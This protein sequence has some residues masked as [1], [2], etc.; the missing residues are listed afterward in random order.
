[1]PLSSAWKP[2]ALKYR[3]RYTDEIL[4]IYYLHDDVSTSQQLTKKRTKLRYLAALHG[5]IF[6]LSYELR[7]FV[8]A[9]LEFFKTAAV[10]A[11]STFILR[12]AIWDTLKSINGTPGKLLYMVSLPIGFAVFVKKRPGNMHWER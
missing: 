4:R 3:S 1:M 2:V 6:T 5:A 12:K 8:H 9:P 10:C 7:Y 11:Y